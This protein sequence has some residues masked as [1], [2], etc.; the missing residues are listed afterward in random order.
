M[1]GDISPQK[2]FSEQRIFYVPG[3]INSESGRKKVSLNK[4]SEN[5]KALLKSF[6]VSNN[7]VKSFLGNFFECF[8]SDPL[9]RKCDS[10][11][12]VPDGNVE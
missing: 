1:A 4:L 5:L 9:I 2:Q 11:E 6:D 3:L 12:K 10:F 7:L 8:Q